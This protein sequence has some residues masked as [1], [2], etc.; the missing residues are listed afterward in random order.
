MAIDQGTATVTTN[1]EDRCWRVEMFI[2]ED[3]S[4]QLV[5]HR[6]I[7]AKDS[8]TGEVLARDK[9]TIP[10]VR[11]VTDNIKTK[12]YTAAGVT[13]T[14]QQILA[15]VNKMA[16]VERQVDID[17]PPPDAML[18]RA[19]GTPPAEDIPVKETEK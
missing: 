4:Q 14:G 5:F 3:L 9:T 17:N 6:E 1:K 11:R 18:L 10:P 16:D 7:R 15:L 12:S 2:D 13:A 19:Q 8:T